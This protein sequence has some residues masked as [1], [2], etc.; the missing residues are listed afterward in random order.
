MFCR[1]GGHRHRW[2]RAGGH[3]V[4]QLPVARAAVGGYRAQRAIACMPGCDDQPEPKG[5][6]GEAPVA[7]DRRVWDRLRAI[8]SRSFCRADSGTSRTMSV[9]ARWSKTA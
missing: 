4:T 5:F 6:Y 1:A 7:A 9:Y 3:R 8:S 2:E